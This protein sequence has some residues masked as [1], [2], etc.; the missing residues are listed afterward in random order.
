MHSGSACQRESHPRY[1]FFVPSF[2]D[3]YFTN[4]SEV[5]SICLVQSS[6]P[7]LSTCYKKYGV[8]SKFGGEHL[9][10]EPSNEID[11]EVGNRLC[12]M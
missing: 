11:A 3:G 4:Y 1:F 8:L 12:M 10:S 6:L 9:F 2:S 5:G 7:V